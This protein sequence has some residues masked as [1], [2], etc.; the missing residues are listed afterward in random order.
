MEE[1][2]LDIHFDNKKMRCVCLQYKTRCQILSTVNVCMFSLSFHYSLDRT[3]GS[4]QCSIF[5]QPLSHISQVINPVD[6]ITQAFQYPV[7]C[8][9]KRP[10]PVLYAHSPEG[11]CVGGW[12]GLGACS[13]AREAEI[14]QPVHSPLRF[15]ELNWRSPPHSRA[16]RGAQ[17]IGQWHIWK[18]ILPCR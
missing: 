13:L 5:L 17:C 15:P 14:L 16:A 2:H 7:I 6:L 12:A 1:I 11:E 9:E 18:V 10:V 3:H 8:D 4:M